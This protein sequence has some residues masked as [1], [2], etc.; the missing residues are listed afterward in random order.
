MALFTCYFL[1]KELYNIGAVEDYTCSED[2]EY[3]Q[4]V[5][6]ERPA[7]ASTKLR[8]PVPQFLET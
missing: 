4:H 8:C 6:D 7:L 1:N 2:E 3:E 5:L